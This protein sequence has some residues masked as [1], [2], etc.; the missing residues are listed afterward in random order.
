MS[1][2]TNVRD[3]GRIEQEHV[4]LV[5]ISKKFLG[6]REISDRNYFSV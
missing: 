4:N 2:K 1:S 5:Q 6:F 3:T